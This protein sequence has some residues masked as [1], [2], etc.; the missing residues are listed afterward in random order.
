MT[1]QLDHPEKPFLSNL[2]QIFHTSSFL[3]L[4]SRVHMKRMV[5]TTNVIALKSC[6]FQNTACSKSNNAPA[7]GLPISSPVPAKVKD[8]PSRVPMMLTFGVSRATIVG[9][10]ETIAPELNP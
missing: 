1:F 4:S 6:A 8:I 9:G 5:P 3:P 10:I 7:I 2:D